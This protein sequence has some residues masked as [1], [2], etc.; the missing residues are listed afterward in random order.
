[1]KVATLVLLF[2][3]SLRF[4]TSKSIPNIMKERHG[5]ETL[6]L[7]RK[8]EKVDFKFKKATLDSGFLYY[9]RNNNLIPTFL[10]F[11]LAKKMLANSD[12]YISYQEKLLRAEIE[13]RKRVINE[14][15]SHHYKLLTEIK[16]QV[17]P[18]DFAHISSIF[19]ICNDKYIRKCKEVQDRKILQLGKNSLSRNNPDKV[20]HNF[21][22]VTLSDRDKYLLSKGLNFA[23]PPAFLEYPGYLV[24]YKLFFRDTL[25]P[26]TSHLDRELLKSRL[27][28]LDFSFFN[29]HN[30]FRKPNN[31]TPEEF[32][33]LSLN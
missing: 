12:V 29:T 1:M 24:G 4:P 16:Q 14:H 15:K 6:K 30:S 32:E 26:K 5:R 22:S 18:I 20:I 21:S 25:S 23:L 3:I 8:F 33:S 19:L 27:K 7:V 2:L 28:E 17:N 13:E 31:L 11:K 9:C 10:K